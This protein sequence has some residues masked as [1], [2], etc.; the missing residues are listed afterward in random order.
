M[1]GRGAEQKRTDQH[2]AGE[3]GAVTP[4][5]SRRK[6][7]PVEAESDGE[8]QQKLDVLTNEVMLRQCEWGGLLAGMISEEMEQPFTIP[9][10]YPRGTLSTPPSLYR[11]L[12]IP[13]SP[14]RILHRC[15]H[16]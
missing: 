1:I 6:R 7:D 14:S 4:D 8:D 13:L 11:T 10:T 2:L 12:Q 9:A 5:D 3:R 16:E 15:P